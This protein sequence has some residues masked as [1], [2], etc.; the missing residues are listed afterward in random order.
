M[1]FL[2]LISTGYIHTYVN[3]QPENILCGRKPE[4]TDGFRRE[5]IKVADFGLSKMFSLEDLTSRCGSPTYVGM[6]TFSIPLWDPIPLS[7]YPSASG[8]PFVVS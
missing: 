8:S 7:T 1:V 5:L 3:I 2:L 4:S 6:Y